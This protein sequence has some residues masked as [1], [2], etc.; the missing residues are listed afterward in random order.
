MKRSIAGAIALALSLSVMPMTAAN[1]A[2]IVS[3]TASTCGAMCIQ[4][5][6]SDAGGGAF[7]IDGRNS[8]VLISDPEDPRANGKFRVFSS[9]TQKKITEVA[10]P[11]GVF[12]NDFALSASGDW[13]VVVLTSGAV[14]RYDT[15]NW[16][17]TSIVPVSVA[18]AVLQAAISVDGSEV[19]LARQDGTFAASFIERYHN[20][21]FVSGE[22][23]THGVLD[24]GISALTLSPDDA[25]LFVGFNGAVPVF[26]KLNAD[27][28]SA[29]V[30][31]DDN[32]SDIY[33]ASDIAVAVDGTVYG[34]NESIPGAY[35][36]TALVPHVLKLNGSNLDVV[37]SVDAYFEWS[38]WAIAIS[39]DDGLLYTSSGYNPQSPSDAGYENRITIYETASFAQFA[40]ISIPGVKRGNVRTIDVDSTTSY[41]LASIDNTAYLV[42]LDFYPRLPHPTYSYTGSGYAVGWDFIYLNPKAKFKWFEVK[43]TPLGATKA[44]V[45]R[46]KNSNQTS[47]GNIALGSSIFVRAMY[48]K[49]SFNTYWVLATENPG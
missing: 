22:R 10:F 20:G 5:K 34:T 3:E 23:Y 46:V 21:T 16:T 32:S 45:V 30:I 41:V 31:A 15:Q 4:G 40:Q 24:Y 37:D 12:I 43:Y 27:D 25:N 39:D 7:F 1:A 9:L 38:D 19:Y 49:S 47:F 28:I 36:P 44:K 26:V 33:S 14:Y 13:A 29:G 42:S 35:N 17:R 48:K 18:G 2:P 8:F 6:Y 11:R